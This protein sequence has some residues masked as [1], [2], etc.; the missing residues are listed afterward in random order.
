MKFQVKLSPYNTQKLEQQVAT[1]LEKMVERKSRAAAPAIWKLTDRLNARPKV[2]TEVQKK[3]A[4]RR[5]I[6]GVIITAL[7]L[8]ILIP[9]LMD[10]EKMMGLMV[11][12]AWATIFGIVH[13]IPRREKK[14]QFLESARK[15]LNTEPPYES[16]LFRNEEILLGN[17]IGMKYIEVTHLLETEDTYIV[18]FQ[19]GMAVL[20]KEYI[21]AGGF[22]EFMVRQTKLQWI[23]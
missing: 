6:Y 7:G 3:R 18:V 1:A 13:L 22:K 9:S 4:T 15:L 14:N 12:G 19:K 16:I 23:S 21:P 11:V 17:A 8:F 5:K 20:Q 2:T 10:L